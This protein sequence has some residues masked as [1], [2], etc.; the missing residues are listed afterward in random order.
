MGISS[1]WIGVTSVLGCRM[2]SFHSSLDPSNPHKHLISQCNLD[3]D[4][5]HSVTEGM[6]LAKKVLFSGVQGVFEELPRNHRSGMA[7]EA[8]FSVADARLS[9]CREHLIASYTGHFV[10]RETTG[11]EI[12]EVEFEWAHT[13]VVKLVQ[14]KSVTFAND[15][16]RLD[17]FF[18]G[19]KWNQ[20]V[21]L[22]L[23]LQDWHDAMPHFSA[24]MTGA[25]PSGEFVEQ[26]VTA[27]PHVETDWDVLS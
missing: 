1:Q 25:C 16:H 20:V 24:L 15:E 9:G 26:P 11:A 17:R 18:G 5:F 8:S 7:L 22:E 3:V 13:N 4:S 19:H 2:V 6:A 12:F 21:R 23:A 10:L 27:G 14:V